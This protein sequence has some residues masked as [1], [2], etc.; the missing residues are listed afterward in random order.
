LIE[1]NTPVVRPYKFYEEPE[2]RV[3]NDVKKKLVIN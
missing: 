3:E 1:N 2:N